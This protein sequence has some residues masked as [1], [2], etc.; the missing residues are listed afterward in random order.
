M[1]EICRLSY[2]VRPKQLLNCSTANLSGKIIVALAFMIKISLRL[3]ACK[4]L[5]ILTVVLN[6]LEILIVRVLCLIVIYRSRTKA[7]T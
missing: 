5:F 7:K 6:S 2:N 4:P 3:V 1:R